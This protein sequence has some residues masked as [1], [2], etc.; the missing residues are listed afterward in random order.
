MHDEISF[1]FFFSSLFCSWSLKILQFFFKWWILFLIM[2]RKKNDP[3]LKSNVYKSFG[4]PLF[5]KKHFDVHDEISFF[6]FSS[7][8][9]LMKFKNFAIPFQI[10]NFFWCMWILSSSFLVV[11]LPVTPDKYLQ[12]N[13]AIP[14]QMIKFLFKRAKNGA[15]T[16]LLKLNYHKKVFHFALNFLPWEFLLTKKLDFEKTKTI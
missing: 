15:C 5:A 16:S 6:F 7:F 1:F 9:L 12:C 8:F 3:A 11:P 14:F 2:G 4:E 10:F 13:I